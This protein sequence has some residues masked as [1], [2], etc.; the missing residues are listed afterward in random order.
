MT[1]L[2][3]LLFIVF[4]ELLLIPILALL[5]L[6]PRQVP[7][8]RRW[9][10]AKLDSTVFNGLLTLNDG[11]FLVILITGAV[12]VQKAADETVETNV[13]YWG[14]VAG[15]GTLGLAFFATI[16]YLVWKRKKLADA[17]T[18]KRCGYQYEHLRF[19][20]NGA[21]TLMYP[22]IYTL[23][24]IILVYTVLYLKKNTVV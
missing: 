12:N 15:L 9:S 2:G 13:S 5:S 7:W 8:V 23:R 19:E 6:C 16:G 1:N 3:C 22:I 21:W 17:R 24:F 10:R 14:A 20:L 11:I 4:F 18:R